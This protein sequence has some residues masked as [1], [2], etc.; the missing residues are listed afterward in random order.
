MLNL[1][2]ST[3]QIINYTPSWSII[4]LYYLS[5]QSI[6]TNLTNAW[7][8]PLFLAMTGLLLLRVWPQR[9]ITQ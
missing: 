3:N 2:Y 1:Y 4:E 5:D 8:I 6:V 7:P 9:V